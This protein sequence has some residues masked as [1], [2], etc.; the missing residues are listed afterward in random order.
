MKK[1]ML[2]ILIFAG[3]VLSGCQ[4]QKFDFVLDLNQVLN[5][6]IDKTGPFELA[7][8]ISKNEILG[9]VD[10]GADADIK[11]VQIQTLAIS[12]TV[13][14]GNEVDVVS[15]TLFYKDLQTGK[16]NIFN[17]YSVPFTGLWGISKPYSPVSLL[18]DRGISKL[19]NK[20]KGYLKNEDYFDYEIVLNG[21]TGSERLVADIRIK[22]IATIEYSECIDVFEPFSNGKDCDSEP[23]L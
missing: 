19:K 8:A 6:H 9:L 23:G 14:E 1:N 2:I 13:G 3:L 17:D 21:D 18:L 4:K 12:V 11:D 5:Y 16:E 22:I 7:S 15:L 20:L 10:I